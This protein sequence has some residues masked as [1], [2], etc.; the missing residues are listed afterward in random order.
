MTRRKRKLARERPVGA[1]QCSECDENKHNGAWVTYRWEE[2]I[3]F[4]TEKELLCDSCLQSKRKWYRKR[5]D[6]R[7]Y[8]TVKYE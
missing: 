5:S 2:G 4:G 7:G 1:V 8:V 3:E 6:E